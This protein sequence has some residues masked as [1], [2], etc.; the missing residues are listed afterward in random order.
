MTTRADRR[1]YH[2]IYKT[3]CLVTGKYYIGMHST[4]NLNDGYVGSGKHLWRSIN[5]HGL[6]NHKLEILEHLPS[7]V[8]LKA[9]EAELVNE[10][11]LQDPMCMNLALGGSYQWPTSQTSLAKER[12]NLS[13]QAFW[14]SDKGQALKERYSAE[15]KGRVF[16]DSAKTNMVA[17][18]KDRMIRMKADGSWDKV[19]AK[20]KT[21]HAGKV[22]SDDHKAAIG[23]GVLAHK[24]EFGPKKFSEQARK[25]IAESLKGNT[26]NKKRWIS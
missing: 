18:A 2:I 19:V 26:R 16:T 4:D 5:K 23:A 8:A 6:N 22:L 25:N 14:S 17:A 12:R 13:R 1:K 21:A 15:L 20:N 7:R 11:L 9:R 24:A 3:T 10:D